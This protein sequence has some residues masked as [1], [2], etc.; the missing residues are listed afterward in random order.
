MGEIEGTP[1][2]EALKEK[3]RNDPGLREKFRPSMIEKYRS[4]PAV[5][6]RNR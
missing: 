6:K 5:G 4:N 2:V 1:S 3:V